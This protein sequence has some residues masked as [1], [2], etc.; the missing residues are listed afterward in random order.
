MV[1]LKNASGAVVARSKNLRG[2]HT[3]MSRPLVFARQVDVRL[4]P[5]GEEGELRIEFNTGVNVTVKF[6]SF[7]ILRHCVKYWR[8][9]RGAKLF[10][11]AV[12]CGKVDYH[13]VYLQ[14]PSV[15]ANPRL[16]TQARALGNLADKGVLG[17]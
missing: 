4:L 12:R 7:D 13:N 6:G 11:N 5:D 8:K 1:E 14:S 3:Y 2:I 15:E 16:A 10:V 17:Q 9:L